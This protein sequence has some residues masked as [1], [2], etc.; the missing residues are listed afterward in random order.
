M[1]CVLPFLQLYKPV[2]CTICV[3]ILFEVCQGIQ[4][5]MIRQTWEIPEL[6]PWQQEISWLTKLR[7]TSVRSVARHTRS[8]YLVSFAFTSADPS[9]LLIDQTAYIFVA[10]F[11]INYTSF[12]FGNEMEAMSITDSFS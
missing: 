1:T 4:L 6:L 12:S 7:R 5:Q 3:F 2:A 10:I 8:E 9:C 11:Q